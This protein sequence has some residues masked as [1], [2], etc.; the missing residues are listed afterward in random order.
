MH[1]LNENCIYIGQMPKLLKKQYLW[2][3]GVQKGKGIHR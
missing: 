3:L 2:V 1:E